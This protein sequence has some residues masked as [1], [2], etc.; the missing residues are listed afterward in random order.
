MSIPQHIAN[1]VVDPTAYA[2]GKRIDDALKWVRDNAPLDVAEPEG[3][4]PFWIASRHADIQDIE[5]R[6]NVFLNNPRPGLMSIEGQ[7]KMAE[8]Q[9]GRPALGML[10]NMDAPQHMKYRLL[11]QGALSPNSLRALED[12]FREIAS[13]FVDRLLK[14]GER[15]EFARDLALLYPLH[16]IMDLLGVPEEDEPRMLK[17]T[18]ELAANTDPDLNRTGAQGTGIDAEAAMATMTE[19]FMYFQKMIE[20]RKANPRGDLATLIANS[21][22]D[23]R[24][25]DVSEIVSYY[26]IIATAGHDTTSSTVAH[27]MWALAERPDQFAKVKADPAKTSG[28]VDE[29]VRWATPVKHFM[30]NAVEDAEVAGRKISKGDWLMMCYAAANRDEAVFADPYTFNIERTPNPHLSFGYGPHVCLGQHLAKLEMRVL[31]ETLLPQIK[32]VQLDGE[33]KRTQ[34]MQLVGLKALPV[35][36]EFA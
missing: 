34:S 21:R 18:Q 31:W 12:R 17:L 4:Q 10:I 26:G 13:K 1:T 25:L 30:R 2:D 32:S 15:C 27:G 6:S 7:R 14:K 24:P 5:R 9:A 28:L 35:R 29:S 8:A 33:V 22:V 20:D 3:Y 16:V 36:F 11:T 23:D 19:F